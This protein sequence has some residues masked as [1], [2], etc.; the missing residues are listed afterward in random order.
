L[1]ILFIS[2]I[3]TPYRHYFFEELNKKI[4]IKVAYLSK[5]E[6]GRNWDYNK[7]CNPKYSL[8]LETKQFVYKRLSFYI[9]KNYKQIIDE[10]N[11]SIIIM[12]GSWNYPSTMQLIFNKKYRKD[13]K[14]GFWSE[15]NFIDETYSKNYFLKKLK[16]TVYNS[17]DFFLTPGKESDKLVN[18][19]AKN[20]NII[21]LTNVAVPQYYNPKNRDLTKPLEICIISRLMERKNVFGYIK[22]VKGLLLENKI[23]INILGDG[24]QKDEIKKYINK[25]NLKNINLL[26][27]VEPNC[28]KDYIIESDI[29][30]L[31]SFRD[32]YPLTLIEAMFL[33][34]PLLVS[35]TVGSVP[36]V[37][38]NNGLI[39]NPNSSKEMYDRTLEYLSFDSKKMHEL[40]EN[41][42]SIGKTKFEPSVVIQNLVNDLKKVQLET[43]N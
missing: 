41:S 42:Q 29:L 23:K 5:T 25:Q 4:D 11:P 6:L 3:P 21:R 37:I 22:A 40:A 31:P 10:Y 35:Q 2:N 26:G 34:K 27:E 14:V 43:N 16:K 33:S 9:A 7:I 24:I 13:I 36:E 15:G 19:Y 20:K 28:V 38:H 8:F 39:F 12:A 1:K 18:H 17:F 32:P 30:C